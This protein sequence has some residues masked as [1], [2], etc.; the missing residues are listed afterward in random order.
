MTIATSRERM[1]GNSFSRRDF[2]AAA[3]LSGSAAAFTPAAQAAPANPTATEAAPSISLT[4]PGPGAWVRWLD[5][6]APE[7]NTGVTRG[8]PWPEGQHGGAEFA[9]V[10]LILR[11]FPARELQHQL[12]VNHLRR[13]ANRVVFCCVTERY[14]Q[15]SLGERRH[16]AV[17]A[18]DDSPLSDLY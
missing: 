17:E 1:S 11:Q 2:I 5:G 6:H 3:G 14:T 16:S 13:E 18:V 9:R 8:V 10:C 12:H 4:N 7:I 15:S